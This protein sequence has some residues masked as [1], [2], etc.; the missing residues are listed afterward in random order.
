M[1]LPSFSPKLLFFP[2]TAVIDYLAKAACGREDLARE[3]GGQFRA[4][5]VVRPDDPNVVASSHFG[6][7]TLV[8]N[9]SSSGPYGLF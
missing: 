9:S 8:C 6:R 1:N 4:L 3:L 2:L 5:A 7:L